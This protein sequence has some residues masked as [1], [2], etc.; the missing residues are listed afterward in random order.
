MKHIGNIAFVAI[1]LL[2]ASVP[3]IADNNPVVPKPFVVAPECTQE[4]LS[5]AITA[6]QVSEPVIACF[7]LQKWS[8]KGA[9]LA[10]LPAGFESR[11]VGPEEFR[12][13]RKVVFREQ[14]ARLR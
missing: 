8:F 5:A 11:T 3:A 6:T 13:I 10:M 12:Q 1:A 7:F 9:A 14:S 2:C 4:Q